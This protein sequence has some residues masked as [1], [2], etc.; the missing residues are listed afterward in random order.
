[1]LQ[2]TDDLI[3]VTINIITGYI[4]YHVAKEQKRD[5]ESVMGDFLRSDTYSLLADKET[6]LYWDSIDGT[7]EMFLDE[8]NSR[9][10]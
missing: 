5:L 3:N 6:G 10:Q 4:V 8:L 1:M 9:H 7:M 2:L